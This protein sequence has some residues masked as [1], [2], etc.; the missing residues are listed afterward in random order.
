MRI[1]AWSRMQ[2]P[3]AGIRR[4]RL[5]APP[6]WAIVAPLWLPKTDGHHLHQAA[7]K[8]AAKGSVR[9]DAIDE[10][11]TVG[12]GGEPVEQHGGAVV[13]LGDLDDVHGCLDRTAH[14]LSVET[15]ASQHLLLAFRPWHRRGCP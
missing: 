11:H 1:G 13:E 10:Y 3:Q 9:L 6:A 2:R 12:F 14:A 5:S 4:A 7:L 8:G 15:V